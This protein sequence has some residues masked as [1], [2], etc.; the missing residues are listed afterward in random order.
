MFAFAC[1]CVGIATVVMGLQREDVE[2]FRDQII[3]LYEDASKELEIDESIVYAR[4]IP[5][6]GEVLNI[7]SCKLCD[8]CRADYGR[9]KISPWGDIYILRFG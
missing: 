6:T 2:V 4:M 7:T 1:G 5:G 3:S 9:V 8:S